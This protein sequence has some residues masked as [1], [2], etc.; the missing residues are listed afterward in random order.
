MP[1][2][3]ICRSTAATIR[4]CAAA[5][6][7]RLLAAADDV[8]RAPGE[9]AGDGVEVGGVDVATQPRRLERDR[10][11][12]AEGVADA[13]DVSE[14]PLAQ[15]PNQVG[16]A[17]GVGSEMAVDC[18]P[19]ALEGALGQLL[20]ADAA[21]E[22]L[23]QAHGVE[24]LELE[25]GATNPRQLFRPAFA[26]EGLGVQA[27]GQELAGARYRDRFRLAFAQAG[28][29]HQHQLEEDFAV[30]GGIVGRGQEQAEDDGAHQDQRLAP[31]PVAAEGGQR[32]AG[33]GLALL[34]GLRREL[35]DPQ[36][37]LDEAGLLPRIRVAGGRAGFRNNV[38]Q[39]CSSQMPAAY[40]A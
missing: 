40:A 27:C 33:V 15:L 11:A 10:A 19:D 14:P 24:G 7:A 36:L 38:V 23:V 37:P 29:V 2:S 6:R 12:A 4:A 5:I 21:G 34:V 28:V 3:T 31:L 26:V 8:E 22:L 9:Q 30:P 16:Q 13:G 20:R 32:L 25:L 1:S 39:A 35:R 18:G 17:F